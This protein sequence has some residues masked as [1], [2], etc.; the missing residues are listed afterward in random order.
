MVT[1]W[2][3]KV[4]DSLASRKARYYLFILQDAFQGIKTPQITFFIWQE[5]GLCAPCIIL[6]SLKR[7]RLH[8]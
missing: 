3:K 1:F 8:L 4:F 5:K 7:H 6:W 2:K